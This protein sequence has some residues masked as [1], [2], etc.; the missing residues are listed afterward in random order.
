MFVEKYVHS[1]NSSDLRDD[2]HHHATIPLH[3]SA[4]ADKSG[5][6]I[7]GSLLARV[8]YASAAQKTFESGTADMAELQRL[9]IDAVQL[10]GKE[11]GWI[12]VRA[13]WDIIAAIGMY[14]RIA[15]VSLAY[16][17]DPHCKE[18]NGSGV[19]LDRRICQ[20]CKGSGKSDAIDKEIMADRAKEMVSELEGIFQAHAGRAQVKMRRAA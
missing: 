10:R 20:P 19:T 16:W 17:L 1:I 12:K 13:E 4:S 6:A 3:A 14:E 5:G 8:K 11:R 18:C 2:E 9:W 15:R 7:P